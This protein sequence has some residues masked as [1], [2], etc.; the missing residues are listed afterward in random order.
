MEHTDIPIRR[1][2]PSEQKMAE[3]TNQSLKRKRGIESDEEDRVSVEARHRE[4]LAPDAS[5]TLEPTMTPFQ[6]LWHELSKVESPPTKLNLYMAVVCLE[7]QY[8]R[9]GWNEIAAK[10]VRNKFSP[11][12]VSALRDTLHQLPSRVCYA[13]LGI[14][15]N[16]DGLAIEHALSYNTARFDFERDVSALEEGPIKEAYYHFSLYFGQFATPEADLDPLF[17]RSP[18][19]QNPAVVQ[20][21]EE[22]QTIRD[23]E[24]PPCH[25]HN[26]APHS[27]QPG[28]A[29]C[30]YLD[31]IDAHEY[32]YRKHRAAGVFHEQMTALLQQLDKNRPRS[33][34]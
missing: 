3:T 10:I 7:D 23:P 34:E 18:S 14:D 17:F 15:M 4:L 27:L 16:R 20:T 6:V 31:A 28:I 8:R 19:P 33:P 30:K 11:S 9:W 5:T 29:L 21:L 1:G 22:E 2:E 32:F 13:M 25:S 26:N 12:E 24:I